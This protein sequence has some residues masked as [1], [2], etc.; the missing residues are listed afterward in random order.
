MLSLWKTIFY[1]KIQPPIISPYKKCLKIGQLQAKF[2]TGSTAAKSPENISVSSVISHLQK[3]YAN[4][5]ETQKDSPKIRL[6]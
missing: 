2:P 6:T 3:P 1:R 4:Y 5:Y